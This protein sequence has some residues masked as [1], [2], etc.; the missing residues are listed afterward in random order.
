MQHLARNLQETR[1]TRTLQSEDAVAKDRKAN[2]REMT[3]DL[4]R[5]PRLNANAQKRGIF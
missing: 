2:G 3:P 4:V 5:T 1:V